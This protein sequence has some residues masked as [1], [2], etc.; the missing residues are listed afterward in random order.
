MSDFQMYHSL[1][2]GAPNPNAPQR[3]DDPNRFRPPVAASPAGYQQ[4][5]SPAY[6]QAP[7]Q[8]GAPSQNTPPVPQHGYFPPQQSP[9]PQGDQDVNNLAS[10]MGA[11][12]LGVDPAAQPR[13]KKKDRHAYHNIE[14][15]G[16]SSQAFN[17]M[18]QSG[19]GAPTQFLNQGS[20]QVGGAQ[21]AQPEI[22]PAMNQFPAAAAPMFSPASP[23]TGMQHAA[24]TNPQMGGT[25]ASS[26]QGRVDPEQIPS[27]PRSRDVPAK[28]YLEHVYPTMEHHLPP[29]ALVPFVAYD[30]GNASPKFA[31]LT[32]NNIPTSQEALSATS[33][34]L[35]LVLQ[36]LAAL[37]EGEQQ[38]PVLDFGETGPPRCRRC[39]AYI[40]PFMQFKSGG[41]KYVCN[42]CTFPNDVP[43]EYFAPTDP[44]G[45]RVDRLQRPE[46]TL[47]TVDFMVPKE[48]WSKEPAGLHWLFLI[49]VTAEAVN[50]GFLDGFCEGIISALYGGGESES[51]EDGTT[52]R[53]LP[54]GAKVG[55]VTYDKE[56][57][58]Y[59][60]S[61]NLDAA[62]MLVMSDIEDP[63]VPLSSGL[64]VDP[65]ESKA[66][67]TSLLTQLPNMFSEFKNPEPALLPT[68]NAAVAA[69]A[70]TGGKV[71]CSLSTLPTWGPG[72]LF[73]R[74]D[75]NIH[76][77]DAEKKLFN[78]EHPGFRKVAQK[79]VESGVGVDFFLAAPSGGYL[80]IATIGHVSATTGGEVFYYPN[81]HSPRD[82]LKLSK[83]IK[84]TVTRETGYQALMK[85]RCSN[86]LQVSAYHG[87]FYHHTFGADLEFGVIDA[88]KSIGV[89][90]SYDG[91]LD[92]K[93]DAH[94]QSAL[95][96]TTASGERR[97]RCSN[98]V[99]SVS[100]VAG[101]CMK[102]V[103]Q[104]AVVNIVA[105]EAAA[106]M[107]EKSL[108]EIRG[109]LTEKTVDI[110]AGYRKN[111][112]GNNP[113]G[114]LVLPENLKE[115]G[116]YVL[117]LVKS[118]AFKGGKE[119]TD[120][121][122]H[123]MRMIKS[124]GP[125]ELSLYLYPRIISIHNLD[126][127][128]GFANENGHLKM[129]EGVRASFSKVEEGGAYIVD[130]G[131][132]C[133]LWLHA[134][135]SPNLL[136]D[137]FGEGKTTLKGL[138]AFSS[139][140]PVLETHLNAQVRN[141][142]Q[143][144][145]STRGSKAL[146]IQLA[147]QGLDGAEYEFARLLYEDRNNEAQSYVDWLVHVHRHIQ[148]EVRS[149]FS[150]VEAFVGHMFDIL[151]E[152]GW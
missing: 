19:M 131:Q 141:I 3:K 128:D 12:G 108:K 2:E 5:G 127:G 36:P 84:H 60:L 110:L 134:Q 109:A 57:H 62:Q 43:G 74:D 4:A 24:R 135:V 104:D 151:F 51:S 115:F 39:R 150:W 139:T 21:W 75:G 22:T 52:P 118:R 90:F 61:P 71:V 102:F 133:L 63:F 83:E 101:E 28:Y 68:L 113:P 64:F 79:M 89:L 142:L 130:N 91:K 26:Q 80:D 146:T 132:I 152:E 122:V 78:T 38:I 54:K 15:P 96:Y 144:L 147:R 137:L 107:T 124:M 32:L 87:N 82:T 47:G 29:P 65:E 53:R 17:G 77:T 76:N 73:L 10:Q 1:H 97:V 56:L 69:L 136:E 125:L 58:F 45:V 98:V 31:R 18:P 126:A 86:G 14:G 35:G 42:M 41:N 100:E 72:R 99:A 129:P 40:N 20:P 6:A 55:I 70:A 106:R 145:E 8:Y 123:D 95:L 7:N 85:V 121:R 149:L 33:L 11:V 117:G 119:P 94:F 48:Y 37:Q 81:F 59:N 116:M 114:Q 88:D 112:S 120:R 50:R 27:V 44:S 46:L 9:P 138:D 25:A 111:F 67:I 140:L 103:D 16:G 66:V 105:K 93:L 92:A 143:Y 23:A 34:P 148:L 13:H 49:D 30:Q